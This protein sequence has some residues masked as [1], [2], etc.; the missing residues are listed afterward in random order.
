MI[1]H[2]IPALLVTVLFSAVTNAAD[3]LQPLKYNNPGLVVDLGVGLWAWPLPMDYDGDGDYDLIVSCPDKPSNGT[4]FFEN[5]DGNVASP[6]FKPGVKIGRGHTNIRVSWVDDKPRIL[7]PGVEF[8][9]FSETQFEQ[10]RK[11]PISEETSESAETA[12]QSVAPRGLRRKRQAR[13]CGWNW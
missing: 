7:I 11:L 1:R 3:G 8:L 6:V 4:Y 9:N 13:H 10:T 5:P 2:L 12:S